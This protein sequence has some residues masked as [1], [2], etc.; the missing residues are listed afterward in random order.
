[1]YEVM[2]WYITENLTRTTLVVLRTFSSAPQTAKNL[3]ETWSRT[4]R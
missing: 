2:R 4:P 1:M 3:H